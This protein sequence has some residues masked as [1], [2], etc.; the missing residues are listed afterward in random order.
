MV[1][2][3]SRVEEEKSAHASF[4]LPFAPPVGG[5]C[6]GGV[7][8]GGVCTDPPVN[9]ITDRCKNITFPQLLLWTVITTR[10]LSLGKGNIFRNICYSV[11]RGVCLQQGGGLPP[12]GGWSAYSRVCIQGGVFLWGSACRG[13]LPMGGLADPPSRTRKVGGMYPTGMLSSFGHSFGI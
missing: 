3:F 2:K 9:R 12:A 8:L 1:E 7:C 6:P 10:K 13:G 4:L 5:V 11:H